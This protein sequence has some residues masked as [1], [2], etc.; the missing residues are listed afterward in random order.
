MSTSVF[1][2]S[3]AIALPSTGEPTL[4]SIV[5]KTAGGGSSTHCSNLPLLSI[6]DLTVQDRVQVDCSLDGAFHILKASGGYGSCSLTFLDAMHGCN[7][8]STGFKSALR[9]YVKLR[10]ND[11]G[12]L[13]DVTIKTPSGKVTFNGYLLGCKASLRRVEGDI[14]IL[15]VTYTLIGDLDT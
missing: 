9:E 2:G 11:K 1:S 5:A 13:M 12:R 4:V 3:G 15:T 7:G 14:A 8:A 6:D 10:K